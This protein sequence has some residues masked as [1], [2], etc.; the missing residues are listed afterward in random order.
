M[1]GDQI[2][3]F[4]SVVL[5]E[6]SKHWMLFL[7]AEYSF[8]TG[9]MIYIASPLYRRIYWEATSTQTSLFGF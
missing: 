9:E 4:F 8:E 3:N 6:A 7:N 5:H 2:S 1:T